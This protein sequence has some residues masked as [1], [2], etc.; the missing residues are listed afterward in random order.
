MKLYDAPQALPQDSF[1][2]K[3]QPLSRFHIRIHKASPLFAKVR[4][5][6]H[7]FLMSSEDL[8]KRI[9]NLRLEKLKFIVDLQ[10]KN[11]VKR[12]LSGR[13][14]LLSTHILFEI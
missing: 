6:A 9:V 10:K 14:L 1:S 2:V 8:Q 3:S 12:F 7:M 5:L 4:S 11:L 13:K